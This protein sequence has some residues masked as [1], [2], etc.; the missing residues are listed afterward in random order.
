LREGI[1]TRRAEKS[2]HLILLEDT[3]DCGV[4]VLGEV[5]GGGYQ[6][7]YAAGTKQAHHSVSQG[8]Q[9]LGDTTAPH[10]ALVLA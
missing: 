7:L 4:P 10:S 6:W 3:I 9:Y 5:L 8:R 1:A 2:D